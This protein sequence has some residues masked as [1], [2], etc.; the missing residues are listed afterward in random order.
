[1]NSL[2]YG[3]QQNYDSFADL[4]ESVEATVDNLES[5]EYQKENCVYYTN[6]Q[7]VIETLNKN[8]AQET[9]PVFLHCREIT[10][11]LNKT[12]TA[13]SDFN[14]LDA[15]TSNST[16]RVVET[17]DDKPI[18]LNKSKRVKLF[19]RRKDVIIKTLLRKCRKFFLKDFS[20]RT[21]YLKTAKR[22]F[23]SSVYKTLIEFYLNT[24]FPNCQ[25]EDLLMFM[26][27]FL[28]PQDME[29]SIDSFVSPTY[30]YSTIKA[31]L[32]KIHEI[33]YKYSHQKFDGFS[34]NSE[35]KILF[36]KFDEL[37]SD[38]HKIDSEYAAGFEIIKDQLQ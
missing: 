27:A 2:K 31:L 34:K 26:A 11:N 5:F 21:N 33:L 8:E 23:G 25:S 7:D 30:H 29:D 18:S 12:L 6:K 10:S 20:T 4:V 9:S 13:V 16:K 22:K 14:D 24:V 19:S 38:V 35:F 32:A 15:V 1:M 17:K 36:M 3:F 37:G 28:Y